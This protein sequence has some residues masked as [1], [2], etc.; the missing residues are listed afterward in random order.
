MWMPLMIDIPLSSAIRSRHLPIS[1]FF[2]M[3]NLP[4]TPQCQPSGQTN[5]TR[6]IRTAQ[7]YQYRIN[8]AVVAGIE[9]AKESMDRTEGDFLD[10]IENVLWLLK[11]LVEHEKPWPKG[12]SRFTYL[13]SPLA[14]TAWNKLRDSSCSPE[15][16]R[17][18][19]FEDPEH[20]AMKVALADPN[21]LRG[22]K[23]PPSVRETISDSY[24]I[25]FLN[26]DHDSIFE[27]ARENHYA[28]QEPWVTEQLLAWRLSGTGSA[29]RSFDRFMRLYWGAW[30]KRTPK[31]TLEL[32]ER[33]QNIYSRYL[34]LSKLQTKDQTIQILSQQFP[35]GTESIRLVVKHYST[36]HR[37]WV[38]AP[39]FPHPS[40]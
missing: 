17:K 7:T 38:K 15:A 12:C 23:M 4:K 20:S 24:R 9:K 19:A 6:Q 25:P 29:K 2:S 33:D 22:H 32:I 36:F 8:G 1:N 21:T 39:L 14:Q 27:F 40:L 37:S 3:G 16:E 31:K 28:I 13:G 35:V 26:G 5:T 11:G 10:F 30:G 18:R 34:K